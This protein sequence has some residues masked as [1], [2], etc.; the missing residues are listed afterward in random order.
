MRQNSAVGG[1]MKDRYNFTDN[2]LANS[3]AHQM[4]LQTPEQIERTLERVLLSVQKPV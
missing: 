3:E 2:N 1:A 4:M